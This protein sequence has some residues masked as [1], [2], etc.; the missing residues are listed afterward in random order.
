LEFFNHNKICTINY[1]YCCWYQYCCL[2]CCCAGTH[3]HT[4]C[5]TEQLLELQLCVM[6]IGG[7]L[8]QKIKQC[9]Y[10]YSYICKNVHDVAL[11]TYTVKMISPPTA[12]THIFAHHFAQK[13]KTKISDDSLETYSL[14]Y[15]LA[16]PTCTRPHN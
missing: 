7:G 3:Y 6:M 4:G 11:C 14:Q 16:I 9:E 12:M 15:S 1:Y 13:K 10:L 5:T 2:H 8:I